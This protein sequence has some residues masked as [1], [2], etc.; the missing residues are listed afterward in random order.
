[1]T[2]KQVTT[3]PDLGHTTTRTIIPAVVQQRILSSVRNPKVFNDCGAAIQLLVIIIERCETGSSCE[4][5]YPALSVETDIPAP[6]LK[7]WGAT[8][9][10]TGYITKT[11]TA[12]GV[13]V[14]VH[15]DKLPGYGFDGVAP[16]PSAEIRAQLEALQATVNAAFDG[17]KHRLESHARDEAA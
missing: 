14:E 3:G 6:T 2:G 15:L 8:L 11:K 12:H 5:N 1:M 9:E 16:D 13:H 10:V 4:I 7:N 17:Y